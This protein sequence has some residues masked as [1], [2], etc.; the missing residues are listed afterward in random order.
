MANNNE[1]IYKGK[2]LKDLRGLYDTLMA[3][4]DPFLASV[5]HRAIVCIEKQPKAP[6]LI[7]EP[8]PAPEHETTGKLERLDVVRAYVNPNDNTLSLDLCVRI[9][10]KEPSVYWEKMP[11]DVLARV[12][13]EKLNAYLTVW[14]RGGNDGNV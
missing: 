7:M 14:L 4:G 6:E 10:S 13:A 9:E 11:Q 8:V 3:N 1:L 12:I 5:M 2:A